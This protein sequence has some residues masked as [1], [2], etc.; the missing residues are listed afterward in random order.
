MNILQVLPE[1]KTGGVETGVVDL[2]KELVKKGHK[3]VVISA[4]GAL[5]D[6]IKKAGGI[7]Y[8]LPVHEKNPITVIKM[9]SKICD[10]IEGEDIDIIHARSRVPAYAGF[11]AAYKKKIPFITT[12]HGYY[13]KHILSRVM[14]WG[15]LIIVASQVMAKHM[16]EDFA[17]PRHKIRLISRGVDLDKFKYTPPNQKKDTGEFTIG[18]IGRITPIKGHTDFIRAIAKV[19]RIMPKIKVLV[20]GSAPAKKE[21]Y[22][23][24]LKT[25][26]NRLSLSKYVS[27]LGNR[28]DVPELLKKMDLLV[29]STTAP[30]A[31]G[32]VIIEAQAAGVPVVSTKVGG[33]VDIIKHQRNGLLVASGDWSAMAD[34][35]V[36]VLKDRKLSADLAK[37]A[38]TDVERNFSLE[39]MY[40]KTIRV[41]EEA[42]NNVNILVIKISAIG[43][44]ILSIPSLAA[45]RKH[46]PGAKIVMLVGTKAREV[47]SNCPY[48][49]ELVVFDEERQGRL[50]KILEFSRILRRE[51]FDIVID[52]QNN[53][54]SRLLGFFSMSPKRIGYKSKKFDF[55][56]TNRVDG[57]KLQIPPVEHQFKLLRNLGIQGPPEKLHLFPLESDQHNIDKMLES[58]WLSEKQIL[59][60]INI[61]SSALW[62]TKRWAVENFIKLCRKFSQKDIRVVVTGS[63]Q[64]MPVVEKLISSLKSKPINMVGKTT[65]M[66]L[67]CLI[68]RCKLFITGDSAPLH[69]AC[70]MS[71]PCIALFGPTDPQRHRQPTSS[72]LV[73]HKKLDCS[74]CYKKFCNNIKC[75]QKI[76]VEEVFETAVSMLK[77]N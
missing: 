8:E 4:G 70:A 38:R 67:A 61:G 13:S 22:E 14:S 30:E 24:E 42:K 53:R 17:V 37:Q 32:R 41:Y 71:T 55:L 47:I 52:L 57:V 39:K 50:K 59:V 51:S 26:V 5:V 72:T 6:D 33:V 1:L 48:I 9:V 54:S 49:D 34:A 18:I 40:K 10:V 60:G 68:K 63:K 62:E 3:S 74:P 29:L 11:L 56:L 45:I 75:M 76:S 43:D 35:I 27:F 2:T 44:I 64:D 31:F 25:L 46:F 19:A 12:C 28:A 20:V 65:L 77:V 21:K 16:I 73:I 15:K 23:A 58:E 7:H 66:E 36:K 69:I